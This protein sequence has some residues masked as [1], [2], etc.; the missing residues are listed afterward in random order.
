VGFA[1]AVFVSGLSP[2]TTY[3]WQVRACADALRSVFVDADNGGHWTFTTID[4]PAVL[5][6]LSPPDASGGHGRNVA[7][8]WHVPEPPFAAL[9]QKAAA[10][11]K[12]RDME[13]FGQPRCR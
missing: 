13:L 5:A 3:R 12:R 9:Y 2:A 4:L 7:P 11:V 6:K 10:V 8:A 1:D